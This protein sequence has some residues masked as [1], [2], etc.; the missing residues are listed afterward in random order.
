MRRL[1]PL[2]LPLVGAC[3]AQTGVVPVAIGD[4]NAWLYI[5]DDLPDEPVPA[6]VHLHYAGE[7]EGLSRNAEIQ[8]E[9][10]EAR[11][12]GVFPEG[13]GEPGDDWRVGVN[14]D[15]IQRDDRG[16]LADV[17]RAIRSRQDVD[18][19]YLSGFS[20]GGA[21]VYDM[22]CLGEDVYDGFLPMGGAMEDEVFDACPAAQRP[23]RHLQGRTDDKWPR[24]TEDKPE[25]SHEGIVDSVAALQ[26][27]PSC[28]GE[29]VM[30]GDC[31]VWTG[32]AADT[33]LCWF[34]GGHWEPDGWLV[35]HRAWID[36]RAR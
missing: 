28:M 27:D 18:G 4:W 24:T 14:K 20:K 35:D 36:T 13:G 3:A 2:I 32:C 15:D 9:L 8:G 6:V 21:M 12:I 10:H 16:F 33:R 19:L 25:S 17:A 30:E 22:A 1:L 31:E 29:P 5:P 7:G 11:L 23:L 34:D 26:D